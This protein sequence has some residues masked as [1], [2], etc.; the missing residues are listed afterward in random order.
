[1]D[2]K[3]QEK[4]DFTLA[5]A[6]GGIE[7]VR[8]D[9]KG[10]A[11]S[12]HVHEGY[13]IGVIEKGAQ[14][15]YRT[16]EIHTADTNSI[17]LVNADDVHTGESASL[18]G[19]QYRAMYPLPEHFENI[20]NDL[21]DKGKFAP[22]FSSSVIND[23]S[24]TDQLRLLFNQ[25]DN[26]ASQLLTETIMYSLMLRLTL[27]HSSLRH[28]PK[29]ISGSKA[30]LLQV[31]EYLDSYPAEDISLKQLAI[32]A[33]LS[34]YHFIR[35]FKKMFELAPHSY[36]IQARL[37]KAKTLLKAGVKPVIV[38][39]DC[40]FHDQSHFNRHFKKALGTSPSKFQKQ[41]VLYK[42]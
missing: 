21:Y 18:G 34:Q 26:N 38:A 23:P 22:Y 28:I 42:N 31:K 10:Q 29:D 33:G 32:I 36:Q 11:F 25:V 9:Y 1:M 3:L 39:S 16:G 20:S 8:A 30:K 40:G 27:R 24:L 35:Q 15:F 5:N 12:K 7:M 14:R 2:N 17:I 41:A 19:W 4:A 37:K 6:Y 13:T